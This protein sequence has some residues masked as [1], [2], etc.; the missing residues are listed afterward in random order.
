NITVRSFPSNLTAKMFGFKT[1]ANFSV[2]NEK[3]IAAPP[4]VDFGGGQAAPAPAG[5]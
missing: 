3:A 4:T 5:R 2:E 1:K